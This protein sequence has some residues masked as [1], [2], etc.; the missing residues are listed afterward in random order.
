MKVEQKHWNEI[1][2]ELLILQN[3]K[4]SHSILIL[5]GLASQSF[6]DALNA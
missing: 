6:S 1:H 3:S 5:R 2:C 4:D